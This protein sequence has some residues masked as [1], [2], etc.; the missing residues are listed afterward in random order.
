M[1]VNFDFDERVVLETEQMESVQ[2]PLAT[3]HSPVLAAGCW[4]AKPQN[5]GVQRPSSGMSWK[6]FFAT[7]TQKG[8]KDFLVLGGVLS[9]QIGDFGHGMY[10]RNLIGSCHKTH[11][12][13]GCTILVK[14]S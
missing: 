11:S 10:V 12:K 1:Q 7:H 3:C 14:L 9:D 2:S 5:S 6:A 4:V 13:D 8:G